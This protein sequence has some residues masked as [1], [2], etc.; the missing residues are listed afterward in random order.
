M[1]QTEKE[2]AEF[3]QAEYDLFA[4]TFKENKPMLKVLRKV[5][6][7][8]DITPAEK[9]LFKLI[10][11]A[12]IDKIETLLLPKVTGDE[13]LH[14][15][16]DFWFQFNLKERT[17]YQVQKDI[18]YLPLILDF[19]GS[20]VSRLKGEKTNLTISDVEYSKTKSKEEN[21]TNVIA[22]NIIL[23]TTEGLITTIYQKANSK[24]LTEEDIKLKTKANSSK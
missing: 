21:I 8:I 24:P 22:R 2:Q 7:G 23:A 11:T 10:P 1:F 16:N 6:L 3:M 18:E 20:S 17:E 9:E 4:P 19:F 12:I 14:G 5:I 13:D 15:V